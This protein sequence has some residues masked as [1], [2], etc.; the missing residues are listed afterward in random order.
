[1]LGA[2]DAG[3]PPIVGS[4][5]NDGRL[6]FGVT[7]AGY[8][9]LLL[10]G[11]AG[12]GVDR[13]ML[14][15][16]ALH[17]TAS[18]RLVPGSLGQYAPATA[19]MFNLG[20]SMMGSGLVN[21]WDYVFALEGAVAF[22][23]ALVKRAN[24]GD[25]PTYPFSFTS[26]AAGFGSASKSEEAR[27][28]LWLPVWLGAASWPAVAALLRRGRLE[29][30]VSSERLTAVRSARNSLDAVHGALT[31]G[32]ASGLDR[33]ER[34]VLVARNGLAYAG[35]SAGA[36]HIKERRDPAVAS[37]NRE[38]LRWIT[39]TADRQIGAQA[40]AAIAAYER[41][42][43]A[44]GATRIDDR[45]ERASAFQAVISA[46][47]LVDRS[48]ALAPPKDHRPMPFLDAAL[49]ERDG[50]LD[51]DSAEHRIARAIASLGN[52]KANNPQGSLRFDL[53]SVRY[54]AKGL[55]Y[56]SDRTT[57][58]RTDT[59]AMLAG[60][61]ARRTRDLAATK[62]DG[63]AQ[64]CLQASA[65]AELR[66]FELYLAQEIDLDRL[67]RL[68]LGYS[69]IHP[70][71]RP[72]A[73]GI[74]VTK[75]DVAISADDV[76]CS[77][78]DV[79]VS[80][81]EDEA[82]ETEAFGSARGSALVSRPAPPRHVTELPSAFA[83]LKLDI[84]RIRAPGAKDWPPLDP[85]IIP[86]LLANAG[87]RALALAERRLR[88]SGFVARDVRELHIDDPLL[89]ASALLIPGDGRTRR[90]CIRAAMR[91]FPQQL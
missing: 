53:V 89:Y 31:L 34:G 2:R 55:A 84:D 9:L 64:Y 37:L 38:T 86:L 11:A 20:N 21:P 18:A 4:G 26:V 72:V 35:T 19:V 60:V 44:Y 22:A 46:L 42:I 10:D 36:I 65:R 54:G 59:K 14:L 73:G 1:M 91:V 90:R 47:G 77:A 80:A 23:G 78:D 41:A 83:I 81:L 33:M 79:T 70:A 5:G 74:G 58:W 8:A 15:Q 61:A 67:G 85:E 39:Q 28:E 57:L 7:F 87:D 16:D 27:G 62:G 40:L 12:A 82:R 68:V 43:Y 48:V 13:A 75:D 6:D 49:L 51:D 63:A 56:G 29:V 71:V 76:I 25:R 24:S 17:G 88:A 30:D 50:P 32:V 3:F 69:L 52:W 66:D 45:K